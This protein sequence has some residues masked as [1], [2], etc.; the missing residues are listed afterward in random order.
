MTQRSAAQSRLH[1]AG[2]ACARTAR[3][4]RRTA[5]A[6]SWR[7]RS[8]AANAAAR[9]SLHHAGVHTAERSAGFGAQDV[10][11]GNR[12]VVA[13]DREVEIV[14]QSQRIASFNER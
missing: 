13:R 3:A 11:I 2:S 8:E 12:K 10:G 4:A 9:R 1:Q 5:C 6:G 7:A 14:F